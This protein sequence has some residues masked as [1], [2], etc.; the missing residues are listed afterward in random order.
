MS[1]IMKTVFFYSEF[2]QWPSLKEKSDTEKLHHAVWVADRVTDHT[3]AD[4][5][6]QIR[7]FILSIIL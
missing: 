7:C 5:N 4:I 3:N 2:S 1:A 6:I